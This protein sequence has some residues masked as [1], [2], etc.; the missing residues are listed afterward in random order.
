MKNNID[1]VRTPLRIN[2]ICDTRIFGG[3]CDAWTLCLP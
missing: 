3:L 1:N 2:N